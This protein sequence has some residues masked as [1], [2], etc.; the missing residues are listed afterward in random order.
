MQTVIEQ[1]LV[2]ICAAVILVPIFQRLGLG[3]VLGYLIA[4][5]VIGPHGFK[6]IHDSSSVAHFSEFGIFFL[7]FIIGLEI[8]PRK[9]WS[10]R[11]QLFGLG[12][13]Q[14]LFC[15]VAFTAVGLLMGLNTVPATLIGFVLSL[16]ST[17]FAVQ[18]LIEKNLFNT[19]RN[20]N[21]NS[22]SKLL[23]IGNSNRQLPSI[24]GGMSFNENLGGINII[25]N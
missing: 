23:A 10:M 16:S 24:V 20:K 4:G 6:W 13:I 1:A 2:F 17:A 5:V 25:N 11:G 21:S 15:T 12:V 3:S 18:T 19:F 14:I 7:L 9:L 22:N 8:Q